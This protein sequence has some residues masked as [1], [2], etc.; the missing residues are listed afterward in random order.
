MVSVQ[1]LLDAGD[2]V[3]ESPVWDEGTQQLYWVDIVRKKIR[4]YH[5]VEEIQKEWSAPDFPTSLA[6]KQRGAGAIVA[7]AGGIYS[8]DGDQEF[9]FLVKPDPFSDN[10]LNEGKCDPNGRFWVGSMQTNLTSEGTHKPIT[11]NRGA[12]FRYDGRN[13]VERLTAHEF[14]ISNTMAW[15]PDNRYFFCADTIRNVFLRYDY[16]PDEGLISNPV[17]WA[18]E[19]LPGAPDGS[20]IDHDGCLWNARFGGSCLARITPEG[21]LDG[22]LRLPVTNPT[23]CTFGGRKGK[24]LFITSARFSL[25]PEQLARNPQEGALLAVELNVGGDP[26]HRFGGSV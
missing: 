23:S 18:L 8:W 14:G 16:H 19:R 1:I 4:T 5:L 21:K 7:L 9:E 10:R 17:C 26:E 3:G 20:C 6:I 25:T 22:M 2:S 24:T 11:A 15:S 12:L 13:G